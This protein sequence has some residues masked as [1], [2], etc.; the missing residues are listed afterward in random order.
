M[1]V[2]HDV[3]H[4]LEIFLDTLFVHGLVLL[5]VLVLVLVH[6]PDLLPT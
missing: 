3:A 1:P 4:T 5:F 2:R 6:N